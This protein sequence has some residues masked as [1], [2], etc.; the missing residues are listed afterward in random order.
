MHHCNSALVNRCIHTMM[1]HCNGA[2]AYQSI[3]ALVHRCINAM[4][5]WCIGA[6]TQWCINTIVHPLQRCISKSILSVHWCIGASTQRNGASA[7]QF[8]SCI[9][10]QRYGASLQRCIST[11]V[12]QCIGAS[13][14]ASTQ[15]CIG[16][17]VHQRNGA[18][19]HRC[20]NAMV[21]Q[22]NSAG[23]CESRNA[24][25]R[26]GTRNGLERIIT[27]NFFA[28]L[29]LNPDTSS[30]PPAPPDTN[31]PLLASCTARPQDT[32]CTSKTEY[33][34]Y[35]VPMLASTAIA[36]CRFYSVARSKNPGRK[37]VLLYCRFI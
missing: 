13:I 21:H 30:L 20:I 6:S 9:M 18:L 24:G 34:R 10:H 14:G 37:N 35:P 15:W 3:S 8:I 1:H 7:H 27:R 31:C 12:H 4:V 17:S 28:I 2:S 11:S 23:T 19:V 32:S 36:S 29:C 33:F 25:T 16:A 5:Y 22:H 26:N